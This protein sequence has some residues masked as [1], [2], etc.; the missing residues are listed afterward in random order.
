MEMKIKQAIR[1]L[2]MAALALLMGACATDDITTGQPAENGKG[3]PFT[4]TISNGGSA[5]RALSG[6]NSSN[7]ITATWATGE[8]VA[9]VY[10][11]GTVTKGA[12][13]TVT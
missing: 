10:K 2:S 5:T 9:L 8:H 6:P 12:D 1:L 3:I 11:V 13:A 7:V 4:A